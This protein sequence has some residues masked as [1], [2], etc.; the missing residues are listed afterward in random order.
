[1]R[2]CCEFCGEVRFFLDKASF[3]S[4]DYKHSESYISVGQTHNICM[5]ACADCMTVHSARQNIINKDYGSR[6]ENGQSMNCL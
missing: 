5:R 6:G 3:R 4:A 1:M 2:F